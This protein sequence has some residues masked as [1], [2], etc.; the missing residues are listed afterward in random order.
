MNGKQ[1]YT[2]IEINV[3]E[4]NLWREGSASKETQY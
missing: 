2:H 1:K 4:I 3:L